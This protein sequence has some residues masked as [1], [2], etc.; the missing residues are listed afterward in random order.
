MREDTKK[1]D[2]FRILVMMASFVV[3]VA[4]IKAANSFVVPFLLS[5]FIAIV[6]LPIINR[7][8][9]IGF[10]RAFAFLLVIIFV[11]MILTV[12]IYIVGSSVNGFLDQIPEYKRKLSHTLFEVEK[13]LQVYNIDF[14]Y[15]DLV[16]IVDPSKILNYTGIFLKSF[17]SIISKSFLIF[18]GTA[19]IL[20]ETV[21]WEQKIHYLS[22][23]KEEYLESFSK[24]I[25]RYLAIKSF[26]SFLTGLLIAMGL[27][28]FG[29]EYAVLLGLI[30][31]LLNFIPAIGSALAFFPA[32]IVVLVSGDFYMILYVA[33]I[34]L[35]V[36]VMIGNII[37][38][39]FLG[40]DL[41]LSV[42]VV[43]L[44][45]LF[46]G[47]VLGPIGMFLAVPISMSLKIALSLHPDTKPIAYLLGNEATKYDKI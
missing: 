32:F 11:I 16:S 38:P 43:F 14:N 10:N 2:I 7:L 20:F 34:Y 35:G 18:L 28:F 42:L 5:V 31:F 45:L 47:F 13:A 44:S 39:K 41:G 22:S 21:S 24:N 8:E 36:N 15:K 6:S 26:F 33:L 40:K 23:Q 1:V 37:E 25:Q 19:F 12:F 46:W 4:G 29:V 3:I 27:Y 30:A 17:S 9:K